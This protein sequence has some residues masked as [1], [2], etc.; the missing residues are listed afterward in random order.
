[1]NNQLQQFARETLKKGLAECTEGEQ[2][3]FKRMYSYKNLELPID[4]V[5]DGIDEEKLD[6][7]MKQVQA[8]LDKK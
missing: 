2:R 7:A 6:W 5:V 3:I 8:T 4:E 1:M